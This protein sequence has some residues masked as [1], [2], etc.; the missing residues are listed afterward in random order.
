M[1]LFS[2]GLGNLH[3]GGTLSHITFPPTIIGA[4]TQQ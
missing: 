3:F 4:I 1:A 2:G